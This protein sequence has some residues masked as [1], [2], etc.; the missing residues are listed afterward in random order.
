MSNIAVPAQCDWQSFLLLPLPLLF[1][2]VPVCLLSE[3]ADRAVLMAA[4][5]AAGRAFINNARSLGEVPVC[6][7]VKQPVQRHRASFRAGVVMR[8]CGGKQTG[9]AIVSSRTPEVDTEVD[10]VRRP[11]ERDAGQLAK[12]RQL[13]SDSSNERAAEVIM[14]EVSCDAGRRWHEMSWRCRE[15]SQKSRRRRS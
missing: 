2:F 10:G 6:L 3:P 1:V 7:D 4:K 15:R 9:Q 13:R 14:N 11:K 8:L 5:G 12:Q